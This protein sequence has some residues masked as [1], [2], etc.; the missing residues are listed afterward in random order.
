VGRI[1]A[2]NPGFPPKPGAGR[3]CSGRVCGSIFC[4]KVT[5]SA[6]DFLD[7][8]KNGHGVHIL[9]HL[10]EQLKSSLYYDFNMIP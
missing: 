5:G 4:L 3:R 10:L 1:A 2:G 6:S 9:K 8:S 7:F